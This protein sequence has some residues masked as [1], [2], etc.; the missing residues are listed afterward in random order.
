MG[1]QTGVSS[2]KTLR[3]WRAYVRIVRIGSVC[4]ALMLPQDNYLSDHFGVEAERAT[5][6]SSVVGANDANIC[7]LCLLYRE[8]DRSVEHH[9]RHS[10]RKVADA[11]SPLREAAATR[12]EH[13]QQQPLAASE[14]NSLEECKHA[15]EVVYDSVLGQ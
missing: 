9:H 4:G 13:R 1:A 10:L 14:C 11:L 12:D 7:S 2:S 5:T 15:Y 6:L 3:V 8:L